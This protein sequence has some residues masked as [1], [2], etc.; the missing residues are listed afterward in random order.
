MSDKEKKSNESQIR[1]WS[2]ENGRKWV[3]YQE[4]ID[5]CFERINTVLLEASGIRPA[6]EILDVGCGTGETTLSIARQFGN[7]ASIL[8]VDVSRPL[9]DHA[10]ARTWSEGLENIQ[11]ELCDV[12]NDALPSGR[13]NYIVSRFGVMFF[14]DPVAAFTNLRRSLAEE[15]S[16]TF[17]AWGPLANN[18]WFAIPKQAAEGQLGPGEKTDPRSPGP[19]AFC[20]LDYV[21]G[22]LNDAGFP[23]IDVGYVDT[24]IT[25]TM[26]LPEV[27]ETACN[28][29]PAERLKKEK[30]GTD[31]DAFE[32]RQAVFEKFRIYEMSNRI[33]IP[34][35]LV[36][37]RADLES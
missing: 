20:D 19:L 7:T 12:Q 14:T 29:G 13:F 32:I 30:Q 16:L 34:V 9:L 6:S 22:I 21:H 27:V 36:L 11:F 2:Q 4:S 25:T 26:G 35:Q 23:N 1:Y 28:L 18:P 8:G 10:I 15:G 24:T 33:E 3:Q 17:V 5:A 37:C 31:A